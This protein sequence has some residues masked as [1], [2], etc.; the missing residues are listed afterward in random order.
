MLAI[1][2]LEGPKAVPAFLRHD[3]DKTH[4]RPAPHA[5]RAVGRIEN[6]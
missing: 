5:Q 4:L 1:Q 6:T 2:A 3:P